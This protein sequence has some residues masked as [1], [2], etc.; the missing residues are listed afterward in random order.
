MIGAFAPEAVVYALTAGQGQA[1][2]AAGA[3]IAARTAAVERYFMALADPRVPGL[4]K[5]AIVRAGEILGTSVA[6][7]GLGGAEAVAT[8][9]P[10]P[11]RV[12][13][14]TGGV[15]LALE[16][17][18]TVAG[19][20]VSRGA[21]EISK[22]RIAAGFEKSPV[23][24]Y[25]QSAET[26]FRRKLIEQS[27]AVGRAIKVEEVEKQ[28]AGLTPAFVPQA[29][30][31][32]AGRSPSQII[33]QFGQTR[34]AL[35]D[36]TASRVEAVRKLHQASGAL[37]AA[38][39][40]ADISE[41]E[42][43]A[44]AYL[45]ERPTNFDSTFGSVRRVMR[46]ISA[47][48]DGIRKEIGVTGEYALR[49]LDNALLLGFARG[50]SSVE[51]LLRVKENVRAH[52]GKA[53][54]KEVLFVLEEGDEA[55][56]RA[57]LASA[58]LKPAK[59]DAV[60]KDLNLVTDGMD[61]LHQ[62][63]VKMG[64]E[65][66]I[67]PAEMG[68]ARYLPQMVRRR[69]LGDAQYV[70]SLERHLVKQGHSPEE[71]TRRAL[72]VLEARKARGYQYFGNV[73]ERRSVT[74]TT[75]QK[76]ANGVPLEDDPWQA[77]AEYYIGM[78]Q[79]IAM[80]QVLGFKNEMIPT[81]TRAVEMEAGP[82]AASLFRS[83]VETMAGLKYYNRLSESF[84]TSVTNL[85]TAAKMG[86]S[87]VPNAFQP[88]LNNPLVFGL[89]NTFDGMQKMVRGNAPEDLQRALGFMAS[90]FFDLGLRSHMLHDQK[91]GIT[92]KLA[93]ATLSGTPFN[94]TER[95]NR[96]SATFGAHAVFTDT[97]AKAST[98]RLRGQSLTF[99]RKV[100][101]E[102]G[103]DLSRV[104][105]EGITEEEYITGVLRLMRRTQFA[106]GEGTR[107]IRPLAWQTPLGRVMMQFNTFTLNQG[108][109]TRDF[110]FNEI[111]KGNQKQLARFLGIYMPMAEVSVAAQNEIA[112]AVT[113]Q[114]RERPDAPLVRAV[115]D[116]IYAGSF[117]M[118]NTMLW[119]A[120]SG[121]MEKLGGP[122]VTDFFTYGEALMD[123]R[124]VEVGSRLTSLP[125]VRYFS[126][127]ANIAYRG[128]D[129]LRK[130]AEQ[131]YSALEKEDTTAGSSDTLTMEDYR[132]APREPKSKIRRK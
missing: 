7:G 42:I 70:K 76:L 38:R 126:A 112:Y 88:A 122:A 15:A 103:L 64:G 9:E 121:R 120:R 87:F 27:R 10:D 79:R 62:I 3:R 36:A 114:E 54:E 110:V 86:F 49:S 12:A 115:E 111:A 83:S 130:A 72:D 1:A 78:H 33:K 119:T 13:L 124:L 104:V 5:P 85:E 60:M 47:T 19:K 8:G 77:I 37:Q 43:L 35:A 30:Q 92:S 56:V 44:G 17:G 89:R 67:N 41:R 74:G 34:T 102:A 66:A 58:K 61:A 18:L 31:K 99:A 68:V 20:A 98:G 129:E 16:G 118:A 48:P 90:D 81:L 117:G 55:A 105:R 22:Q 24:G 91:Q 96:G 131:Y 2:G 71:A 28:L 95:F 75:R 116:I 6:V 26:D 127:L 65:A 123:G 59:I 45:S 40:Y 32:L 53:L 100:F 80:G 82:G 94:M 128:G 108:R 4:P 51:M 25:L 107:T 84:A 93:R 109:L 39:R 52:V 113:G 23:R 46:Q 29:G 69:A 101:E 21:R 11:L 14:Q 50:N 63:A 57:L 125:S 97:L 132:A 106:A 73:D